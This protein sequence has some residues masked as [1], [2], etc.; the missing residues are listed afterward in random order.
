[1]PEHADENT[2]DKTTTAHGRYEQLKRI[3]EPYVRRARECAEVTIP[4]MM[5]PEGATAQTDLEAPY[6]SV[7]ARGTSNLAAKLLLALFPPGQS[8]FELTIDD[9]VLDELREEAGG[10]DAGQD[11]RAEFEKALGSI[12]RA[13]ES[14]VEQVG[15]RKQIFEA[16]KQLIVTGNVLLEVLDDSRLRL[17]RLTSYVVKRDD[18]GKIIEIILLQRL[19]RTSLPEKIRQMVTENEELAREEDS[20]EKT[21]E[22]YT[23]VY[24]DTEEGKWK[25]HQEAGDEGQRVPDSDGT[26]PLDKTPFIPLRWTAVDGEDYGRSYC[27]QY[28]G[29]LLSLNALM[30]AIVEYSAVA[31]RI[32]HFVEPGAITDAD[33]VAEASSGEVGEGSADDVTTLTLDKFADFKTTWQ[34]AQSI[35]K[36]LEQAFLLMSGVQ[37]DAERVTAEEVR[38]LA[39]ELEQTLG[40]VYTVLAEEMQAPL[41]RR[42]MFQM[43]RQDQLPDL[44][45]DAVNFE[46]VTGLEAIGR[47]RDL[48]KLDLLIQG[49]AEVFGPET[50][51]L[52]L[53]PGAYIQRRSN[54]LSVD[55]EGL[56]RTEDEVQE[57]RQQQQQA[58]IA[59]KAA[60]PALKL[61]ETQA[62]EGQQGGE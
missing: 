3:R 38:R 37:R 23:W 55:S 29:D 1:M 11:A 26:Y 32:I 16:L 30:Q 44:P 57:L 9:F 58:E 60:G 14:R 10:I 22:L 21:V 39:D 56:F 28:L 8:F 54:A 19:A 53:K 61:M 15:A 7:G 12:V 25:V 52:Y 34:T 6:Q 59:K 48:L 24:R 4:S 36:R 5:P 33:F 41:I 31:S 45:E 18:E 47:N 51:A 43:Q 13:V 49:V 40:G 46:I 50:V 17:H 62:A 35:Q 2:T 20:A 27:E 42:I